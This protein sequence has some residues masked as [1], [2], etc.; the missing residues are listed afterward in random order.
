MAHVVPP[1]PKYYVRLK[2]YNPKQGFVARRHIVEGQ[3]YCLDANSGRPT[4]YIVNGEVAARRRLEVQPTGRPGAP[5]LF[6]V[7]T[8]HDYL[9]VFKREEDLR[10]ARL[11]GAVATIPVTPPA[12]P[13]DRVGRVAA[14]P[15]ESTAPESAEPGDLTTAALP[16]RPSSRRPRAQSGRAAG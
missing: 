3:L 2:P 5:A 1:P 15:V 6:D 11:T 13:V 12:A 14:V 9:E 16:A 10:I 7:M 8:E 4:W